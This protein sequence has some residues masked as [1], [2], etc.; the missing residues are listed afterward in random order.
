MN[1]ISHHRSSSSGEFKPIT[2]SG[3]ITGSSNTT[4]TTSTTNNN[5]SNNNSSNSN[6]NNNN[7]TTPVS[8]TQ[9]STSYSPIKISNPVSTSNNNTTSNYQNV[10]S[11]SPTD[12]TS[13]EMMMNLSQLLACFPDPPTYIPTNMNNQS[14]QRRDTMFVHVSAPVIIGKPTLE[15]ST[16]SN[17]GVPI[18]PTSSSS[19]LISTTAAAT[20]TTTTPSLL[21]SPN[22]STLIPSVVS[23]SEEILDSASE[24]SLSSND[25]NN[26]NNSSHSNLNTSIN[27]LESLTITASTPVSAS[28]INLNTSTGS[29]NS[30]ANPPLSQSQTKSNTPTK[31]TISTTA[32]TNNRGSG[33]G[34]VLSK[35]MSLDN[36]DTTSISNENK[37]PTKSETSNNTNNSNSNTPT[38]S[39][40]S[41]TQQQ[42]TINNNKQNHMTSSP[43][44][45]SSHSSPSKRL[46]I[47]F[48]SFGRGN[49]SGSSS[50]SNNTVNTIPPRWEINLNQPISLM[51]ANNITLGSPDHFNSQASIHHPSFELFYKAC[52]GDISMSSI[53]FNKILNLLLEMNINESIGLLEKSYEYILKPSSGNPLSA[54]SSSIPTSK[55]KS[56]LTSVKSLVGDE[57]SNIK[58]SKSIL[59]FNSFGKTVPINQ[60]FTD[61]V[62]FNSFTSKGKKFKVYLGPPSKTHNIVVTPKEGVISK[63]SQ[64]TINFS[65]TLKSS[66]KLRRVV[67][68]EIEGGIR[69]FVLIQMESNKTAF[70]QPLEDSDFVLDKT[71]FGDLRVPKA[72]A[73]LKHSFIELGGLQ[74]DSVFRSPASSESDLNICKDLLTREPLPTKDPH[75]I[76][77]LIKLYFRELP[78]LL[79]NEVHPS[80]FLS[81]ATTTTTTQSSSTTTPSTS[82]PNGASISN[83]SDYSSTS[84]EQQDPLLIVNQLSELKKSAFLWLIDLLA[85]VSNHESV[86][87]MSAKN[88]SI[89]FSPNL[90]IS[91]PT[92]EPADSFVISGR[93]VQFILEIIQFAKSLE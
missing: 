81:F 15:S 57:F 89:I 25:Q 47:A 92:C 8:P 63:K 71:V 43:T 16:N 91:P 14:K 72:L 93:V 90:Y 83:G 24:S 73:I 13:E 10:I 22:Q 29:T 82:S 86:N 44:S 21:T 6:N 66:I 69:Y 53:E 80:V 46:T 78:L 58:L 7:T 61:E 5:S 48:G 50:S 65:V 75:C 68:I 49:N 84:L 70:G 23:S 27:N 40:L 11:L 85:H 41:P 76:A 88:L 59:Y 39:S 35:S 20:T 18:T 36:I 62:I 12:G 9:Q 38:K 17:V 77:S 30:K 4:A 56:L 34:M 67:V 54:S 1:T 64:T 37:T 52:R 33:S 19:S 51:T 79:L 87:K 31:S 28:S 74:T 55:P 26:I 60:E 32:T 2:P 42:P 45:S 3:P